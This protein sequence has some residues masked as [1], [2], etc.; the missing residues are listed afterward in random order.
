MCVKLNKDANKPRPITDK[1]AAIMAQVYVKY[2][3]KSPATAKF[4]STDHFLVKRNSPAGD[5]LTWEVRGYVDA[6][7]SF[8]ATVRER[9]TCRIERQ[10]GQWGLL[11]LKFH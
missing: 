11:D 8:G 4:P 2:R 9:F 6:Q 3:L 7:N 1:D 10:G 5:T